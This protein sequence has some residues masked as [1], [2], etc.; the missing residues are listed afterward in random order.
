MRGSSKLAATFE[1]I[2]KL[3][4]LRDRSTHDTAQ[5]QVR[6]DKV[7]AGGPK[8]TVRDVVAQLVETPE[9]FGELRMAWA[10]EDADL[11]LLDDLKDHLS[12]GA[13]RSQAE[14]AAHYGKS[15][16]TARAYIERGIRAGLWTEDDID[17]WIGLGKR[18]RLEGETQE[19][20]KP[21]QSW[22]DEKLDEDGTAMRRDAD[23]EI[24]F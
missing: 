16:P 13:F 24:V 9:E 11:L 23:S 22:R 17:R 1:T 14:I 7:R 21:D 19:P 20:T 15:P 12:N 4:R 8:R 10:L 2:I 18:L 5:F 3:E 6:W